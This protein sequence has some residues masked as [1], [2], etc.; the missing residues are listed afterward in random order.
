[1]P[2]LSSQSEEFASHLKTVEQLAEYLEELQQLAREMTEVIS[3]NEQGLFRPDQEFQ[4]LTLL[5]GYWQSRSALLELV[6]SIRD[7]ERL[8]GP[9]G[10]VLFLV[11]FS[12]AL[13]LVDSARFLRETVKDRPIV[14]RKLN[15]AQ[16][17]FGIP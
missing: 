15:E 13:I 4:V 17:D 1:M 3:T 11:G 2:D 8:Y 12:A 16:P 5:I 6:H 14:R 9:G 7:D 10:D